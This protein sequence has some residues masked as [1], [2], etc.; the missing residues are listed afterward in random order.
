MGSRKSFFPDVDEAYFCYFELFVDVQL[1][2]I[3]WLMFCNFEKKV[4]C[5]GQADGFCIRKRLFDVFNKKAEL[6]LFERL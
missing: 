2:T 6:Q 4:S 1:V 5:N 3:G